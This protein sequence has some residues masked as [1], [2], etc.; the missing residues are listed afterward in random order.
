MGFLIT[1]AVT[2]APSPD[3]D[4]RPGLE[5]S[6]VTPGLLGFLFTLFVVVATVFLVRDMAKRIRR[7][8]YR[9]Q[10]QEA[11]QRKAQ[12]VDDDGAA[13]GVPAAGSSGDGIPPAE[14]TP[15]AGGRP[16]AGRPRGPDNR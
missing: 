3:G 12:G 10:V 4:L 1:L 15:G 13:G 16:G 11:L 7:V 6:Q 14:G 2:P 8:R 9:E 5:P